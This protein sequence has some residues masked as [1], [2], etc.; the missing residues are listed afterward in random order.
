MYRR[1]RALPGAMAAVLF[2]AVPP[3]AGEQTGQGVYVVGEELTYNVRFS[4]IDLGQIKIR[5]LRQVSAA[6]F[7]GYVTR[8]D[9]ASYKSIPFVSA[10]AVFESVVD[11]GSFSRTFL[12]KSRE[13][14]DWA[15]SRYTFHYDRGVGILEIGSNDTVITKRDT[16]QLSSR[17]QD[18]LS[19]FFYA[20]EHLFAG[21]PK[22]VPTIIREKMARTTIDFRTERESVEIDLVEYPVDTQHFIGE[23]DFVGF[24]GL[25]GAFEGWFS[26]DS[27]RVPIKA[28]MQVLIGNVTIELMEYRR[29][30]WA[31]PRG[32]G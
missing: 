17:V 23:A 11:T 24:Y 8:A 6:G 15:F 9:I 4:F 22:S 28:S 32:K 2:I 3:A 1:R 26:N 19:L 30:G 29:P 12:G 21:V 25:T 31:P 14:D 13:G 27:A 18:G 20:R 5:T 10:Q 16:L 7:Q